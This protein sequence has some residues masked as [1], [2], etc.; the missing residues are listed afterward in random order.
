MHEELLRTKLYAPSVRTNLV[1]RP[2]LIK[3]LNVGIQHGA[4]L[5]L[6]AAPAGYGK[7]TLLAEWISQSEI[8]FCWLS[9]DKQDNDPGRFLS[10][11]T[12]SLQSI[13]IEV[14]EK[15]SAGLL[16]PQLDNYEVLLI[17]LINQISAKKSSFALILDDYHLI[18]SQEVHRMLTFLLENHPQQ[19]H[20]VIA[21]LQCLTQFSPGSLKP[22]ASVC[23]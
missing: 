4:R 19:M 3:R 7:T 18:E 5:T 17:S 15:V 1:P 12:A 13:N 11:F 6:I 10:Y 14:D 8:P 23:F 21:A 9:L 20:L 16:S 22:L 2:E